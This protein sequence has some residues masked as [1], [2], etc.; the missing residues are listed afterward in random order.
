MEQLTKTVFKDKAPKMRVR[1]QDGKAKVGEIHV[2]EKA[3]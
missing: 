1:G 3:A 2:K